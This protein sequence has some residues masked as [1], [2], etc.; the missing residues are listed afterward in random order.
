MHGAVEATN[1]NVNMILMKMTNVNIVFCSNPIQASKQ[2]LKSEKIQK[3][4]KLQVSKPKN[5]NK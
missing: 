1:K 3:R 5:G 2:M 4:C